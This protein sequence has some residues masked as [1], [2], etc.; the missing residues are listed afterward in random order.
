[1][2]AAPPRNPMN[3][4]RRSGFTLIELLVAVSVLA[5]MILLA[6][7]IFLDTR[8]VVS[9]GLQTSQII[10]QERA[11]SDPLLKDAQA[12][13][14]AETG[15]GANPP[16]FLLIVQDLIVPADATTGV[17]FPPAEG[18]IGTV[19]DW[20]T[21]QLGNGLS[22]PNERFANAIR[23]DQ[24]VF[25][26]DAQNLPSV[27]PGTST[28]VGSLA[29][30][31]NARVWYGHVSPPAASGSSIE[32]GQ[33]GN[34]IATDLV[35]GRQVLLL[36]E[37]DAGTRFPD[38]TQGNFAP[39]GATRFAAD[40]SSAA[41]TTL[42]RVL[43]TGFSDVLSLSRADAASAVSG[44]GYVT[45]TNESIVLYDDQ[46]SA[47]SGDMALFGTPGWE[48]P[49][50][51]GSSSNHSYME[52]L[53]NRHNAGPSPPGLMPANGSFTMPDSWPADARMPTARYAEEAMQW[54]FPRPG[55]RLQADL[56]LRED[57]SSEILGMNSLAS[58]HPAFVP[59]V[60][61]FAVDFAADFVDELTIDATTGEVTGSTPDGLPDRQ[62][63][64]D[65]AGNIRWYTGTRANPDT[66]GDGIGNNFPSEPVSYLA[67]LRIAEFDGTAGGIFRNP[68]VY[69]ID[70]TG[71]TPTEL[72]GFP[73]PTPTPGNDRVVFIF[74][75]SGDDPRTDGSLPTTGSPVL[76]EGSGKHWPYLLRVRYR[77]LDGQG[78][79]RS[80]DAN[81]G[82]PLVGR[83]FE[84]IIP[85]PRPSGLF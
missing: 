47:P 19:Q 42:D 72:T 66:D 50:T 78:R 83:W 84:Q 24:L 31:K 64:R 11:I 69:I 4:S 76:I 9:R 55:F 65:T 15:D 13:R 1:M 57:Y 41:A 59:H 38:G 16:G 27:T 34:D 61:D 77:L 5:L 80:N 71:S 54:A 45:N 75:H 44:P 56:T 46:G 2:T 48:D 22:N 62:P 21:D 81:T 51:I 58:L 12:M 17:K 3:R 67:P 79:Y 7:R 36:V 18:E 52:R 25:F 37:E 68:Y 70:E 32:V 10:A 74:G 6:N 73:R 40:R 8:R 43:S 29:Q 26:R 14:F 60:A 82:E 33:P 20:T 49:A 39:G 23:S 63:D 30:A 35:L 53:L 85:V 28:D